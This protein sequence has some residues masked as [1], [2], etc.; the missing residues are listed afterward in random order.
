MQ[1]QNTLTAC[2]TAVSGT[3]LGLCPAW[4]T[5]TDLLKHTCTGSD[6]DNTESQG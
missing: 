4:G 3:P 6:K 1:R 2:D 5:H